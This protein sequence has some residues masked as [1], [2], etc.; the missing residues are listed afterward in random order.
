VTTTEPVP[1][2]PGAADGSQSMASPEDCNGTDDDCDGTV[3]NNLSVDLAPCNQAGACA[4]ALKVTC[5]NKKWTCAYSGSG[6]QQKETLCD[7]LDNDCNGITDDGYQ[8]LGVACDGSDPD[9]CPNGK[10]VCN[11]TFNAV[12]CDESPT[13]TVKVEVCNNIDDDCNG[14][15]DD[16]WTA[17]LNVACDGTDLDKCKNGKTAC[18]ADQQTTMC[19]ETSANLVEMCNSKDDDCNGLTDDGIGLGDACDALP[20]PDLCKNGVNVCDPLGSGAVICSGD[21]YLTEKCNGV[22]D[23]CNGATDEGFELVGYKCKPTGSSC[24]SGTY[25][26]SVGAMKCLGAVC[27]GSCVVSGSQTVADTCGP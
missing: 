18:A 22:D 7:S 1:V 26:C 11:A 4:L 16:P 24:S 2:A 3:D 9:K 27:A 23:N 17:Q 14:I 8:N 20:D 19:V 12:V 21:T 5:S 13:G 15:T 25:Q 6:Y 10:F